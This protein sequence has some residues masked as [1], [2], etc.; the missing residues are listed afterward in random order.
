MNP[1]VTKECLRCGKT[2]EHYTRL[3]DGEFVVMASCIDC[4]RVSSRKHYLKIRDD[5]NAERR[6]TRDPAKDKADRTRRKYGLDETALKALLDSQ[7]GLCAIC[8]TDKPK[9]R[10]GILG[11]DHSHLTGKVRGLI[12]DTEN[13]ILGLAHDDADLLRR[14]ADYLDRSNA[15]Q[16]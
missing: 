13:L 6:A 10:Y 12:C 3:R 9:S 11:V 4:K 5:W 7:D 1:L 8:F 2:A 14:C 16:K 15:I